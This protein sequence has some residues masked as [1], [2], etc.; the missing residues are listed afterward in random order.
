[1]TFID[2]AR[3]TKRRWRRWNTFISARRNLSEIISISEAAAHD[4]YLSTYVE[5]QWND[6]W[7]YFRTPSAVAI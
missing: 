4:E 3:V 6:F 2:G 1:M 7:N 5:C